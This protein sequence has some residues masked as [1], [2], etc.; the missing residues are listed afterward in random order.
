MIRT[1]EDEHAL[2][3]DD[4]KLKRLKKIRGSNR[5]KVTK[6]INEACEL[7]KDGIIDADISNKLQVKVQSLNEK[8]EYLSQLD[9]EI[10]QN[11]TLHEVDGE[12]DESTD[13]STR[14]IEYIVKI[15]DYLKGPKATLRSSN[16]NPHTIPALE[17]LSPQSRAYTPPRPAVSNELYES[18]D[19]PSTSS[20]GRN[21]GVRLPKISLPRFKGDVTKFQHFWQSFRCAV[22]E[23]QCLS[24]VHKLNYL[25]NSLEGQAYKAL[26]GLEIREEN[27][28]MAVQL[29]KERFGK[30]QH[31]ISAHMQSLLKLQSFQN[32]KLSDVRSIYDT[33]MVHVRGLESLGVSSEKYGS[34]LVPVIISRMPED[35][36]LQVARKTSEDVWDIREIMD[37]IQREIEAREVSKK[38]TGQDRRREKEPFRPIQRHASPQG[39]TKS[40]LTKFETST[41]KRKQIKCFFCDKSHFSNE[42]KEITDVKDRRAILRQTNRCFNCLRKG[43]FSKECQ[44]KTK[45]YNC[46][47]S[48]NTALCNQ[49]EPN[50]NASS[51]M[52]EEPNATASSSMTTSNVHERAEVL[53]QTATT[54][55]FGEDRGKKIP[56]SIL[57]DGGSQRSF[58]SKELQGRLG[59]KPQKIEKLNLNTFGSEMYVKTFS[60]RVIVNLEVNEEVVSISALSSP[61]I[62]SPLDSKVDIAS[63]PHLQGLALADNSNSCRKR[64]DILIGADHYYDIVIGETIRGSAGPVAVSSKLGWLLSGPVSFSAENDDKSCRTIN[65][66][67]NTNLVLD[68]LPCREEVIDESREIVDALDKFWKHEDMGVGHEETPK[69]EKTMNIEYDNHNERYQVSLPWKG[70]IHD[71]LSTN[72]EMCK[73][74]LFS[75]FRKLK[76]NPS[77]LQQYNE[78]FEQQLAEGVI[79]KVDNN[80]YE[81]GE[82][83]FLCH[84]GVVRNDRQTTKLRVVFDGSARSGTSLSL[85]DRLDSGTNHMPLLFDTIMRFRMFPIVLIA[86]IEKAFLQ[87][88][89]NPNDRDVLRFLWF[90]DITKEEPTIVQFRYCRLVFGLTCSPA[91]LAETINYHLNQFQLKYPEVVNHL[92]KLYCDDFSCGARNVNEALKIYRQSKEI[93][94]AGGFNLR[95][96]A[97]NSSEVMN[98][99]SKLE[100]D[101]VEGNNDAKVNEDDQTYSKYV[102]GTSASENEK[103]VLG[104]GWDS[105]ADIL[106]IELTDVTTFAKGL[107]PT[108]RSVLRIAAKIF[109]PM[110]YVSVLV[111]NFKAFF[112]QLCINKCSWDDELV[113]T[114]RKTYNG[115][116]NALE[117]FPKIQVPRYPFLRNETVSRVEIHGFSDA[118][119]MAYATIVYLRV[120]Y[121]SGE[122]S[123]KFI[124]SKSKVV[125]IKQQ[126]IP[127]LELLGA[128]LMVKLVENVTNVIQQSLKDLVIHRYYWV[129]SMA[130]LCWVRNIKPWTQY[131]R[132]RISIILQKSNREEWFYC[133]G[134][135]NPADLPSRGKHKNISKNPLWLEGPL[136]LK[137]EPSKWPSLPCENELQTPLAMKERVK[138]EQ[139]ITH[140]MSV[141]SN[142]S[143]VSIEKVL[144]LERFSSKGKLIRCIG[145]VL[146]FIAKLRSAGKKHDINVEPMLSVSEVQEAEN[147]LIRSIQNEHFG[148]EIH[149]LSLSESARK[150]M[151]PPLYV[152]QFNLY[153]DQDEILRCRSRI[154]RSTV[155]ECS[156]RPILLPSKSRFSELV[157]AESHDKVYHNGTAD[158]LNCLRQRYWVLRGRE[159]VKRFVRRCILCKKI[160]GLSFNTVYN[161]ELPSFRVDEAPPF[162]NV[163][164]DMAGPLLVK[165]NDIKGDTYKAYVCLFT[166]AATRAVHLELVTSLSVETFICVFRRFCARRGLPALLITDNAKTFRSV[167]KEVK[168]LLRSPR[169]SEYFMTKG[170]QWRFIPELSPFQG[171]FWERMVRST[172]RCLTKIIGRALLSY[173][174][175]ATIITEIEGVINSRPITYIVDDSDGIS[176]PLTPS[177]LINGRNLSSLPNNAYFE[178][179]NTYEELSKRAKYNRRLLSQ[180]TNR[181]KKEY[182]VSLLEKYR[183]RKDSMFNPDININD[184]CILR[185]EQ[186]KRAFWKLC[187][188]E[189]L[190]TGADGSTRSAKVSVIANDGKKKI[191]IRSLKHLIPLEI[192]IHHPLPDK[193]SINSAENAST[194]APQSDAAA[195]EQQQQI[196]TP[197]MLHSARPKRNAATIGENLRKDKMLYRK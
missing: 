107:P 83:H 91:I 179:V 138:S 37:I 145:W 20:N 151:K 188:V 58:V 112:Q 27:Y 103:K 38:I 120:I 10:L 4:G 111:V 15:N 128:C 142:K 172:K 26:E 123:T 44:A 16:V 141:S 147:L 106:H 73:T 116:I 144:D 9:E 32:D 68:I 49:N 127:R 62:C 157:I 125:P 21:Q 92:R 71:E 168:S 137:S 67:V 114:D 160:E 81:D 109:D 170:V 171:G 194:H 78:V 63:Y 36:A 28:G 80:K 155:S 167:S 163:G 110:G 185:N 146:R 52:K 69:N 22:H 99:I 117:T 35:I 23:N 14:I 59:L 178:I 182:L 143:M 39:T 105:N 126:S 11:C 175:L 102:S 1:R 46:K 7:M 72:Y 57:F 158:T 134:P 181:W 29:L 187:K 79:E 122:I 6:L 149:Y 97:S 88:Q 193:Q 113:G 31:I 139:K 197:I 119:E 50:S 55:A 5:G 164:I 191:L 17:V 154:G 161:P 165:G 190:I 196:D 132:N 13:I 124:A 129:D 89:V 48:H 12:V 104:V 121:E 86:D 64:V 2:E 166:C 93:M 183:P 169:L 87:V 56:V 115:L 176:Y 98:E 189:E 8:K 90:D 34:L 184:M 84:F 156:K 118:S 40:F 148:K 101:G 140:A 43:H 61:A 133:P 42:C 41:E 77:L 45:C 192:Q 47:G 150:G 82:A 70:N 96:W 152:N 94:S 177:Q 51:P 60:D 19:L 95:K 131:V 66:V 180:F 85:N 75:L 130:V 186:V 53:L 162:S 54:F 30:T 76:E 25:V 174:E 74:R 159:Q 65:D 173:D 3:A 108:K 136:F 153:L 135:L 195:P 33:I 18:P 100:I 24:D